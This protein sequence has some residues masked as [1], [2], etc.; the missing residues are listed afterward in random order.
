[1][2]VVHREPCISDKTMADFCGFSVVSM[3][4]NKPNTGHEVDLGVLDM[5][6]KYA[7]DGMSIAG[8]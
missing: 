4:I 2:C 8:Y 3:S 6:Q 7:L 1:M 5:R